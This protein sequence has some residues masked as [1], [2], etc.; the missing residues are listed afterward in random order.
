MSGTC[1]ARHATV[2]GVTHTGGNARETFL[3]LTTRGRKTG[4][5]RTIEIW[6]VEHAGCYYV[7][8]E[9]REQAQWVQNIARESAVSFRIGARE[10]PAPSA[11]ATA[12]IVRERQLIA[13]AALRMDEKYAWSDGLVVEICP[14][15]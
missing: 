11:P 7:V 13:E 14:R 1:L 2:G 15:P 6:F 9:R 3:Y 5:P 8:A 4:L 12:R 10:D